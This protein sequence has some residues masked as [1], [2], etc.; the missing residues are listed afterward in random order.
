M[1]EAAGKPAWFQGSASWLQASPGFNQSGSPGEVI[2]KGSK[3]SPP[4]AGT[5]HGDGVP[6]APASYCGHGTAIT[7]TCSA[8]RRCMLAKQMTFPRFQTETFLPLSLEE[9]LGPTWAAFGM[10]P[11]AVMV[12]LARAPC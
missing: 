2:T 7:W 3:L 5:Q 1:R 11:G 9:R 4:G 6:G 8:S 12:V 10:D